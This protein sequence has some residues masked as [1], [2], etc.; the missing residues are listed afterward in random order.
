M[1]RLAS[2]SAKN[3]ATLALTGTTALAPEKIFDIVKATAGEIKGSPMNLL[4]GGA[5]NIGAK[6]HV[7]VEQPGVLEL[8]V[9]SVGRILEFCTFKARATVAGTT[10]NIRIGGL[11]R[12]KTTQAKELGLIP[13]GPKVIAG[14]EPYRAF[15]KAVSDKINTADPSARLTVAQLGS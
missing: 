3:R 12:Y 11:D 15:L 2:L 13:I 6:I 7:E 4:R 8:S 5:Q 10:T 1:S 14:M 9:N